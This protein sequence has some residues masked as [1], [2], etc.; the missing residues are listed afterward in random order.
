VPLNEALAREI[1]CGRFAEVHL[2]RVLEKRHLVAVRKGLRT[3]FENGDPRQVIQQPVNVDDERVQVDLH[4]AT[5][6]C[7]EKLEP[8]R[9]AHPEN[10]VEGARQNFQA[11][12]HPMSEVF[13]AS[14]RRN[15]REPRAE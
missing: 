3:T 9:R 2:H 7:F 14:G 15:R 4:V 12:A 10:V 1:P 5:F 6:I 13:L 8:I 11:P